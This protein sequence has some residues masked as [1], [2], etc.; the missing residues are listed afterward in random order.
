MEGKAFRS[1]LLLAFYVLLMVAAVIKTDAI[2]AI[3][4]KGLALMSPLFRGVAIAFILDG[5]YEVFRGLTIRHFKSEKAEKPARAVSAALVHVLFL[6]VLFGIFYY[7]IPQFVDSVGQFSGSYPAYRDKVVG[8][9]D[10]LAVSL[11]MGAFDFSRFDDFISG[12]PE[13]IGSA[14]TGMFPKVFSITASVLRSLANV[15][16]GFIL[17]LYILSDKERI[18]LQLKRAVR[19]Y[20]P[21]AAERVERVSAITASAYRRFIDGQLIEA[22]VLGTMCFVGMLALGFP[23]ALPIS[24]V[25]GISNLIPVAGPIIGTIPGFLIILLVDPVKALWFLLFIIVLQQLEGNIVYPR[26][27]GSSIGLPSF[28]L[29]LTII[30][31]GGLFGVLG[32]VVGIPAVTV[33]YRLV[34]QDVKSK[35]RIDA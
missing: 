14:L 12:L 23:Y 9:I 2:L 21:K 6:L 25:I 20:L 33:L 30:I 3:L 4:S 13:R 5:P 29:L 16:L 22:L 32:I 34:E 35:L 17:S 10:K 26:V 7:I 27:M 1:Y 8:F 11:R 28:W 15:L 31:S 18:S 19:A 24:L